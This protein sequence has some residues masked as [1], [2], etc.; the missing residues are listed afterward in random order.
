MKALAAQV[1]IELKMSLRQ[2]EQLLVGLGIPLLILVFFSL[3]DVLPRPESATE[4]VD[5]LAPGV[6]GLAVMATGMVSLAISTGFERHYHVLKRL[7][8]TPLGR[9]RLVSAKVILVLGLEVVQVIVLG[10]AA[11]ALGWRP[12][13]SAAL[14]LVAVLL[15]TAAF[16]GV[17][18]LMA[19]TLRATFTLALSNALFL[20]LLLLGGMVVPL[21]ELPTAVRAVSELLPAAALSEALYGTLGAGSSVGAQA[22]I[23]LG[24]WAVAAPAAAV[25]FFRWD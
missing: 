11:V 4:A 6:L 16:S 23:V 21:E 14:A 17:G 12:S 22:W 18:L 25:A 7:G 13:G 19:G 15:G 10:A 24:A 9:G 20:V 3:V 2:G 5:F 8:A 1:G